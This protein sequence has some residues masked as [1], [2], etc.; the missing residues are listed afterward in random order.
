M[1]PEDCL[2]CKIANGNIPSEKIYEDDQTFAF[3]DINPINR[4][5]TLVIPKR[6]A[7]NIMTIRKEE[8]AAVMETVRMLAPVIQRAVDADGINIGINNGSAAGQVIFHT[9]VHI[10]PRFE[11]DGHE[12]WQKK[13]ISKES[14]AEAGI[15]IRKEL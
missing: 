8:L 15:A 6:H 7:E 3:L 4:G 2:F 11:G 9:H 1:T 10:M 14:I 12:H 13:D 5:H